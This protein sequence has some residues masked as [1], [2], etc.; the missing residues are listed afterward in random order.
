M[1]ITISKILLLRQMD[2][3]KN[4]SD[5]AL[6]DLIGMAS[7]KIFKAHEVI[8]S[9]A[10]AMLWYILL[11]GN[12]KIEYSDKTEKIVTAFNTIGLPE[13]FC[14]RSADVKMIAKTKVVVLTVNKDIL[15]RMF[16]LHPSLFFSCMES[17]A[18]RYS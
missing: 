8:A 12:I 14:N 7:E 13:V 9:P 4:V 3:F 6:A 10:D 2:M 16:V 11:E 15:Y 18:K 1:A 17:I 5:G